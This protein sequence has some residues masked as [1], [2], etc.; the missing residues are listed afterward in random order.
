M[1]TRVGDFIMKGLLFLGAFLL[2]VTTACGPA[3]SLPQGQD[4]DNCS[5]VSFRIAL[6]ASMTTVKVGGTNAYG[7]VAKISVKEDGNLC[8]VTL[9]YEDGNSVLQTYEKCYNKVCN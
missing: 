5:Q 1:V 2:A 9:E 8:Y 4:G 7:K 6:G 3:P